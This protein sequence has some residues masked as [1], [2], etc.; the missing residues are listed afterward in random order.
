LQTN[1]CNA[2]DDCCAGNVQQNNT[3]K[4]DN[5]GVPRCANVACAQANAGCASSADCC[6]GMPCVPNPGFV[7]DGGAPAFVCGATTCVPQNGACT[8]SADC[9][10]G[11]SC[12][13]AAGSSQGTCLPVSGGCALY[14]QTYNVSSDCCNGVPCTAG[15]CFIGG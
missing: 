5:L 12:N 3:C 4:Q 2:T 13:F 1:Q 15:R 6:N 10:D 9:C 14:G 8:T 7:P 11:D